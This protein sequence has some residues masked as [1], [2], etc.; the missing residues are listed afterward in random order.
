MESLLP[1]VTQWIFGMPPSELR[2]PHVAILA[3]LTLPTVSVAV[4]RVVMHRQRIAFLKRAT[5]EQLEAYKK[6]PPRPPGM[7]GPL[8]LL[9]LLGVGVMASPRE[10]VVPVSATLS[11]PSSS[12][13]MCLPD[14]TPAK[15]DSDEERTC[16]RGRCEPGSRCNERTCKCE[17]NAQSPEAGA[18]AHPTG[19][20]VAK[21]PGRL[22]A[23]LL[24][25]LDWEPTPAVR[26]DY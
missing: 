23:D 19:T 22:E 15:V 5:R 16:C 25:P 4:A 11:A 8:L 26:W 3:L 21:F 24:S 1:L 12:S 6:N 2:W 10:G 13:L 20:R 17:A 14:P 18:K 9:A 7:A